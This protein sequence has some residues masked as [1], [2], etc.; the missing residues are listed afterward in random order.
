MMSKWEKLLERIAFSPL[1]DKN[2]I[3][4]DYYTDL[5]LKPG[6]SFYKVLASANF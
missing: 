3:K 2:D 1:K 5:P 4:D 6:F